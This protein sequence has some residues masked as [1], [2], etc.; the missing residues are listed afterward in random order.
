MY[1][2][3][4]EKSIYKRK[5]LKGMCNYNDNIGKLCS[6]GKNNSL[7]VELKKALSCN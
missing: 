6:T 4:Y 1:I 7:N 5:M 2:Y 3:I